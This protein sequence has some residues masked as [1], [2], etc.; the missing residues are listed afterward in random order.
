MPSQTW[1]TFPLCVRQKEYC[2]PKVSL[3]GH[4]VAVV[5]KVAI[6][7]CCS[8]KPAFSTLTFWNY[9][10]WQGLSHNFTYLNNLERLAECSSVQLFSHSDWKFLKDQIRKNSCF[11]FF[12]IPDI[13]V[14]SYCSCGNFKNFHGNHPY[15]DFCAR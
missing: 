8:Q 11:F 5:R 6:H 15:S 4:F 9:M 3:G 14:E 1:W 2:L 12:L 13:F 7:V 10:W